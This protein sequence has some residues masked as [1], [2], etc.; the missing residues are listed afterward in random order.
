MPKRS[1]L[2][3]PLDSESYSETVADPKMFRKQ[4]DFL[5]GKHPRIFPEKITEGY[6]LK[7]IYQS[8]KL[9]IKKRRIIIDGVSYSVRPSFVLPYM[10]STTNLAD[11]ALFL[12]K[13]GVPFWALAH[14]FGKDAMHW[15]RME[16]S[17]G[18]FSLVGTTIQKP[19]LLPEH[20]SADE[21]HTKLCGDKAFV[22]TT[23]ADGCI[24]GVS[25][26]EGADDDSMVEAYSGYSNE[27]LKVNPDY[28]PKT[29]NIDGWTPTIKAWK[30]LFPNVVVILCFLHVYIK[31][32]KIG[33]KEFKGYYG[34]I[35]GRLWNA[36]RAENRRS[37]GQRVR[38]LYE[39]C[40]SK[41]L[42]PQIMKR[43]F[44]LKVSVGLFG[45]AYDHPGSHRTSN[46]L[47]RLMNMMDR[48]LFSMRY[49]HGKKQSAELGIRGWALIYNFSPSCPE[50]RKLHSG[51]S[52]PVERL[53]GFRYR[54]N[55]L[56][57]L[58]V[59]ASLQG[60]RPPP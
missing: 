60:I 21:K 3:V 25:I 26:A 52:C 59:S 32:R 53:N 12:R 36:Y 20:I 41:N 27:A 48:H 1:E 10:A 57:N 14:V 35:A 11:N 18:R 33:K 17:L 37:F 15:H 45:V 30:H 51:K 6:E 16:Q 22:A 34:A 46:M 40:L 50:T 38:R 31:L 29:V 23:V 9:G 54:E 19:E 49:F 7:D 4:I 43:I 42:S 56:E 58:L 8:K 13:F 24:F 55:W 2:C 47:D 5:V 39:Y 28:S 44:K